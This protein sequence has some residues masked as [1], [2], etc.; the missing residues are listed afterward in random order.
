MQMSLPSSTCSSNERNP[1]GTDRQ[2]DLHCL[3]SRSKGHSMGA[4]ESEQAKGRLT[5]VVVASYAKRFRESH[6]NTT[7]SGIE[8]TLSQCSVLFQDGPC[9]LCSRLRPGPRHDS[10]KAWTKAINAKQGVF[11]RFSFFSCTYVCVACSWWTSNQIPS[12]I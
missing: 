3:S 5:T 11:V 9:D 4:N 1:S 2:T 12:I 6:L 8:V 7:S 10:W